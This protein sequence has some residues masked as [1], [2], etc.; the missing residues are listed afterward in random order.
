MALIHHHTRNA[1][2]E[3]ERHEC[4]YYKSPAEFVLAKIPDG[5]PFRCYKDGVD[6]A[7]DVDAMCED[8]EFTII[9]GAGGGIGKIFNFILKP[10]MK[11]FMPS[12]PS[13]PSVNQQAASANNSLTDRNNKPRPYERIFDICGTVQC[14]P[15]DLMQSYNI[16]DSSHKQYQYG[17]YYIGRGFYDT[18]ESG[19]LDG[20]TRL[21]TIT[22]SSACIYDPYTSPN[23]SAPRQIIGADIDE[24]L[25]ITKRSNSVDGLELKAPNEYQLKL[26]DATISCQLSGT[27]GTLVDATG[28]MGFDD[29]FVAGDV[30]SLS[31]VAVRIYVPADGDT[32]AH[33]HN[34]SLDG[35]YTVISS[36]ETAI[37]FDVTSNLAQWQK[38]SGGAQNMVANDD[39]KISPSDIAEAGFTD[40]FTISSIKSKR[41]V[42]NIV[43]RQGMYKSPSNGGATR[44]NSASVELQW[45]L[46]NDAGNHTGSITSVTQALTDKS[47]DEVGM[48]LVVNLPTQSVV[49]VRVRRSTN[50]DTGYDGQSVDQLTFSDLYGQV[51]DSTPHYGNITTIHTK[52]RN[53]PQA[54]AVKEPQLKV[55]CT[56]KL[57]KYLGNG[58]F[59][60]VR[61]ENTQ[62]VQ[63]MIRLLRDPQIGAL[64]LSTEAMD[65]LI[66]KQDEIESYFG[67]ALAGQFCYTFD[68][69]SLTAQDMCQ[70]IAEAIFCTI[71][72]QGQDIKLYFERPSAGPAMVFTNR[73]KLAGEKWS[74]SFGS[75]AK[76][77]VEFKWTDPSDNTVQTLKIPEDGGINPNQ[78]E[79]KGVRNYQQAYWLAHRARQKDLLRRETVE[80][81]STE[82]GNFVIVG[83][84]ISVV[85]G[86]RV[87][88]YDGYIVAQNGLTLT[89]SQEVEFTEG[90]DHY[91]QLKR[92]DGT[93]ESIGVIAGANK[94]T[95][96][97]LSAPSE[98]IYTQNSAVKTEFSFGNEARHLAQMIVPTQV[99]P[100]SD[101]TVKITGSNYHPDVFLFD[102]VEP[103]EG[104][105]SNGYSD[106]YAN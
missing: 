55:L 60:T 86:S 78:I 4:S 13:A 101:R 53:T 23:N 48:S 35:I 89:L 63:S 84:V 80:F 42:A 8:G 1:G 19:V 29:I 87:A 18:P 79:G 37:S 67:S 90:D 103:F 59:D 25:F 102:G 70:T 75:D 82:E 81:T 30:I 32:F 76:D 73:S 94:R 52:R 88:S 5:V 7:H 97:M 93:V 96:Q 15:S 72:R 104:A 33:Y 9:E 2:G 68:D 21:S 27:T 11:L 77:S 46:I 17:Y 105:Y 91:I 22:G 57:F 6:I 31:N 61:T 69:K 36:G 100:Q 28:T 3:F 83:E 14:I 38:I 41:I 12:T 64:N 51:P 106:G 74:R 65:G 62:A 20:D 50:Q 95:V 43:A 45:Q 49:R 47:R 26:K 54:T 85:K 56:E 99:E 34:Q 10:I 58:V 16:Y 71:Y 24:P 39:A 98:A 92:R 66:D 40:W 44:S